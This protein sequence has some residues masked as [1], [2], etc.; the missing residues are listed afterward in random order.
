[1]S[2]ATQ[3][4]LAELENTNGLKQDVRELINTVQAAP[5]SVSVAASPGAPPVTKAVAVV[6]EL[7]S[8]NPT[9][10]DKAKVLTAV[11]EANQAICNAPGIQCVYKWNIG[12]VVTNARRRLLSGSGASLELTINMEESVEMEDVA[13]TASNSVQQSATVLIDN[14]KN[15]DG[16]PATEKKDFAKHLLAA[17][18]PSD[19]AERAC[20]SDTNIDSFSMESV[21][22]KMKFNLCQVT[23]KQQR[24]AE[25]EFVENF[26]KLFSIDKEKIVVAFHHYDDE[27][28]KVRRRRRSLLDEDEAEDVTMIVDATTVVNV[29]TAT[30]YSDDTLYTRTWANAN[31][32]A[33]YVHFVFH[34]DQAMA[35]AS[36]YITEHAAVADH[37]LF[38]KA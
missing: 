26:G 38:H 28:Y 7:I 36:K 23:K 17:C 12:G 5:T 34:G 29:A 16:M 9:P 30:P 31:A 10:A 20:I 24:A 8:P 18:I 33:N 3:D 35:E 4:A 27:T 32:I 14:I 37:K 1:L 19:I 22:Y 2:Q 15:F 11:K 21:E 6:Y 25:E 13:T